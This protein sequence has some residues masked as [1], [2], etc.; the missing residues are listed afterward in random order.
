MEKFHTAEFFGLKG[1]ARKKN[2]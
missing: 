2:H 1:R